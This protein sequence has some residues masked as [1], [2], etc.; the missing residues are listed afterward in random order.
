MAWTNVTGILC[1]CLLCASAA[2]EPAR[3]EDNKPMVFAHYMV[4]FATYGEAAG[5][6]GYKREIREAEAAG[7]DGFILNVGAWSK[8]KYYQRRT[9][10]IHQAAKD[11][12]TDFKLFFSL[13]LGSVPDILDMIRRFGKHPNCFRYQGRIVVSTF[14]HGGVPWKQEVFDPLAKE[15]LE[16][17][18]VPYFYPR[19]NVT[20]LPDYDVVMQVYRKHQAYVDGLFYFGAAGTAEQLARSNTAYAKAMKDVGKLCM[21]SYSPH[22]W[23]FRQPPG[24]RYFE[25]QGGEGTA[26]QWRAIIEARPQWVEIVTWNDFNESSW[27]SPVANPGQYFRELRAPFRHSHAGYLELS[28]YYIRWYK[29]GKRPAV[30]RDALFYFYRAHPKDAKAASDDKPVRQFHGEVEDVVY[31]TAMLTAPAEAVVH[32]GGKTVIRKMPA[33]VSHAKVPF[34]PGEQRFELRRGDKTIAAAAGIPI[35]AKIDR[36]N[37]F[38]TS[39]FVYAPPPEKRPEPAEI[40]DVVKE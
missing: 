5:V 32:T 11:M 10:M 24:R 38:P 28:K 35:R 12:G 20:E 30:E 29:T 16:V 9:E 3:K 26:V 31:L 14:A 39:G 18:F 36:Y 13:D 25:T 23:G 21:A 19:P 1:G 40:K 37:F 2:A 17:F 4:C 27:V 7:I 6:E 8:E 22:Y 15:G 34:T 33:G